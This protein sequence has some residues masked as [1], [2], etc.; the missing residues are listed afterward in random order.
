MRQDKALKILAEH[1]QSIADKYGVKKI[2]VF[3]WQESD[4]ANCKCVC[5]NCCGYH[6]DIK[7]GVAVEYKPEARPGFE[8]FGLERDIASLFGC[9]ILLLRI[10]GHRD[11]RF[12]RENSV[13]E[14]VVYVR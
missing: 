7:I 8:F 12:W 11:P 4:S 10:D 13:L 2:G 1:R 6:R 14:K 3:P 5:G 9:E